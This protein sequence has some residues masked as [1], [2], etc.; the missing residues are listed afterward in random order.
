MCNHYLS[1]PCKY[2]SSPI[3]KKKTSS[4]LSE[5]L[6]GWNSQLTVLMHPK[7][8]L[9]LF[10][11]SWIWSF[12]L[13]ILITCKNNTKI[14]AQRSNDDKNWWQKLKKMD[15]MAHTE[16]KVQLSPAFVNLHHPWMRLCHQLWKWKCLFQGSIKCCLY[17]KC[18]PRHT[19]TILL[20]IWVSYPSTIIKQCG[21]IHIDR[22]R[23]I[24]N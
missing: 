6:T 18:S 20:G 16:D 23:M 12:L 13:S 3:K 4:S 8:Q 15:V 21:R 9:A 2:L 19:Q 24:R 1:C 22:W 5:I 14:P 17:W 7:I 10:G 11:Q